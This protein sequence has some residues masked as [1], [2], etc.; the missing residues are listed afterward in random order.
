MERV[1][2]QMTEPGNTPGSVIYGCRVHLCEPALH[3]VFDPVAEIMGYTV[4]T[5]HIW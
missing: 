4:S 2:L 5:M 3:R 1:S